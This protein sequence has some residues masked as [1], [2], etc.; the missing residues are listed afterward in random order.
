M[1]T[2]AARAAIVDGPGN[3]FRIVEVSIEMPQA[4]EV[5]VDVKASGI[6]HTDLFAR[7][8]YFPVPFPAVFG[9]EGAGVVRAVG[10]SVK[11]LRPGDH[12]L[13]TYGFCGSCKTCQ[14][15][16]PAYCMHSA[17]INVSGH[18]FN[19]AS[20]YHRGAEAVQA[21]FFGHSSFATQSLTREANLVKIDP[22]LPLEV[23]APLGCGFMTGAGAVMNTLHIPAGSSVVVAGSG[24][25][26]LAAILA[27]EIVG[28]SDIVAIDLMA[29]RLEIAKS[30]G[31]T[32]TINPT[33]GDLAEMLTSI[34]PDGFD[35]FL[36]FTSH[37]AVLNAS[38]QALHKLGTLLLGGAVKPGHRLDLD[39]RSVMGG[40][41]VRGCVR[42]DCIPNILLPQLIDFFQHGKFPIDRLLQFYPFEQIEQAIA[43]MEAGTVVKPVLLMDDA[44]Q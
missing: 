17:E 36:D 24:S 26:G 12:V 5:L 20:A 37:A 9:H 16:R 28:A 14:S 4:D 2:V 43:D 44:G 10:E 23:F 29:H 40:R 39:F 8:A 27:A 1:G 7:D 13:M 15:G 35:Y 25:V 33:E 42:G 19:G 38:M 34:K 6:C 3:P 21:H 31:A 41:T 22:A 30:F 18:R 11:H 32:H